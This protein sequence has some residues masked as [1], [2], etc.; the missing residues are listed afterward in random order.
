MTEAGWLKETSATAPVLVANF[1]G[2]D[3]ST[4][5]RLADRLRKAGIGAEV[6]PE[7]LQVGKQLGY[8]S[9]RGHRLG[10]IVGP[11]EQ[12]KEVFNL[13]DLATR[14]EQ[15]NIPWGELETTVR[16]ALANASA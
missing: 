16:L 9:A 10:I 3:V 11:D 1:P 7:P 4:L 12:A 13:R 5:V 6:F 2:G 14:K 15:K 8:G